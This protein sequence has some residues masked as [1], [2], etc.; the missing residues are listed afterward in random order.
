MTNGGLYRAGSHDPLPDR[1][2]HYAALQDPQLPLRRGP[3]T[4]IVG[5]SIR[6]SARFRANTARKP[7]ST[8]RP[9]PRIDR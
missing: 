6:V 5:A 7:S 2:L 8:G 4:N 3:T 9:R 1:Y